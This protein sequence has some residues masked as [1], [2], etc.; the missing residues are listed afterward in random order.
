LCERE[1]ERERHWEE[2]E[3][4]RKI[5]IVREGGEGERHCEQREKI[6][7]AR[8]RERER[9]IAMKERQ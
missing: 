3:T 2:R 7:T 9:E 6:E 1:G 5:K 8:E 4:E